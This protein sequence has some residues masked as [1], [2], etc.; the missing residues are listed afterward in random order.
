MGFNRLEQRVGVTWQGGNMMV[1]RKLFIA[2]FVWMLL[3]L[4]QASTV[5]LVTFDSDTLGREYTYSVYLPE[6][7]DS[8]NLSYSVLYLLHG[9]GGNAQSWITNGRV[10]PTLDRLIAAGDIPPMIVVMPGHTQSWWADGNDEAAQTAIF[11]DLM[12]HVEMTYRT[13]NERAGRLVAGLSAGGFGTIN[14]VMQ[15]PEMFAA[16]AALSPAAYVPVPPSTS[17]ANR[18]AVF[19]TDGEFD[20]EVW[21]SLNYPSYIDGYLESGTIVPMYLNSGDHDVFDI[22]YHAAVLYQ[23]LREHQPNAVEYRVVDGDHEWRVWE[24]TIDDALLYITNY[25]SWPRAN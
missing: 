7:Y 4:T 18:H 13:I 11:E 1:G 21:A 23:R 14:F 17:S 22:A 19:Q 6:G 5:Q 8:S 12:P 16:G 2:V 25:V 10:I 3:A 15:F 9:A 24:E 20:P